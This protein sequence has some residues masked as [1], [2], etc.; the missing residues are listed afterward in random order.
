MR[1][2]SSGAKIPPFILHDLRRTAA[3]HMARLG[4]AP[5]VVDRILAHSSGTIRGVAAVYN[6]FEY[7][8][9]RRSALA[10]WANY[11]TSL[12]S[13]AASNVIRMPLS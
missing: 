9:E 3:S 5:H 11:V 12:V 10:A 8:E 2:P 6:R 13:P 4:I 7:Q 1:Q